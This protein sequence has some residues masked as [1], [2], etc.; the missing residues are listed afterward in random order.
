MKLTHI[1]VTAARGFNHPYEQ[2]AN[3]KFDLHLAA[4][5][6]PDEDADEAIL[7]LQGTAEEAAEKHKA[8]ILADCK[9]KRDIES[10]IE[11]LRHAKR[12]AEKSEGNKQAVVDLEAKLTALEKHK[13]S[14]RADCKRKRDIE[15][16]IENLRHAKREAEKSEGNKQAVVDLEA[17][18]TALTSQPLMIGDKTIYAGHSD[19]PATNHWDNV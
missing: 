3:F 12:E 9:R 16:V 14:S 11:N 7:K 17:K 15:S 13:A 19:H 4:N 18:L 1:A 8:R 2:F 5:L 10:V 6:E